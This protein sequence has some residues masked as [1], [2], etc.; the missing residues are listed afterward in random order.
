MSRLDHHEF[1][2]AVFKGSRRKSVACHLFD[3]RPMCEKVLLRLY[4]RWQPGLQNA[5]LP[6]VPIR[7]LKRYRLRSLID[8]LFGGLGKFHHA[9][10]L[11]ENFALVTNEAGRISGEL[12][13]ERGEPYGSAE[14]IDVARPSRDPF[15]LRQALRP[16]VRAG[17]R[18]ADGLSQHLA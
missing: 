11:Y 9:L 6:C 3:D 18:V 17:L 1:D 14:L 8:L 7:Y 13:A 15:G 2:V 12:A 4:L 16:V 5:V 10:F